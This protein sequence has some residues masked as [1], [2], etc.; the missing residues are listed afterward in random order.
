[1]ALEATFVQLGVRLQ[2]LREALVSLRTT[3]IE[4]KPRQDEVVLVSLLGDAADDLLGWLEGALVAA[5]EAQQAV[6]YPTDL[7][8]TRR[9]LTACQE[10]FQHLNRRFASELGA[11]ER[12]TEL[13]R[14]GR[15]RG[16]EWRGWVA[17]VKA[18]LD[19]CQPLLFKVEDA[20]LSCWQ[21]LAERLGM[22]SISVQATNIGQQLMF[23]E[24]ET[25]REY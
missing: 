3:V 16:G 1:M 12:L 8:R 9:A 6:I 23:P 2:A 11:Y 21:E 24:N 7:D 19:D 15:L 20:F 13:S 18:A 4:D 25:S 17:S 10:R 5:G 14:L 22:N